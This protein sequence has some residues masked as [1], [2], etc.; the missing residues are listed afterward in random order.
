MLVLF[1]GLCAQKEKYNKQKKRKKKK[2]RVKGETRIKCVAA[3]DKRKRREV[4][5]ERAKQNKLY[6]IVRE[7]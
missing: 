7:S 3:R 6:V 4:Q 1:V 5:R 2:R